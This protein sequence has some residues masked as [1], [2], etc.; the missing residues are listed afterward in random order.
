MRH[1]INGLSDLF[2][3]N[4]I[5]WQPTHLYSINYKNKSHVDY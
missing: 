3:F 2:V 5:L 4:E 1:L